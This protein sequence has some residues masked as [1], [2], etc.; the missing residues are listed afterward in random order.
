MEAV[1]FL[2]LPLSVEF[3]PGTISTS[4]S[5]LQN[6]TQSSLIWHSFP[7]LAPAVEAQEKMEGGIG[8]NVFGLKKQTGGGG[9]DSFLYQAFF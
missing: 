9:G 1:L 5:C 8:L 7:S 3:G 2:A 4:L 6:K